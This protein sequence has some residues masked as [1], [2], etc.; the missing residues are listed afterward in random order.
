MANTALT[1]INLYYLCC[2]AL[3]GQTILPSYKLLEK[4]P[5]T[6]YSADNAMTFSYYNII[7]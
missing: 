5:S 3:A 7:Y 4:V 6:L 1:I 2:L